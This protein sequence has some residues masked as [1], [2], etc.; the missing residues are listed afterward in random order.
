MV[1]PAW[2]AWPERDHLTGQAVAL[3]A[4]SGRWAI[5]SPRSSFAS[6]IDR[7]ERRLAGVLNRS[8]C[9]TTCNGSAAIVIA[10]QA[11]GIGPGD[12]VLVPATTWVG[13]ATAVLRVGARPIFVDAAANFPLAATASVEGPFQAILAVHLY[14]SQLE[15]AEL[16]AR[17]PGVPLIEDLSHCVTAVGSDG[18]PLG[19]CGEIA[20]VSFQATKAL[21]CGEG[22][23]AFTDSPELANRLA[24]LRADSRLR[25][26]AASGLVPLR[27]G[28]IHGANFALPEISAALLCEQIERLPGQKQRR[29]AG[30]LA[31]TGALEGSPLRAVAHEC[32][33]ASGSFYGIPLVFRRQEDSYGE[34]LPKLLAPLA[35]AV[36][37]E[38]V[39]PPLPEGPLYLPET[40]PAYQRLLG[41]TQPNAGLKR[42]QWWHEHAVVIPHELLLAPPERLVRL[43]ADLAT[44]ASRER[45]PMVSIAPV[46]PDPEVTVVVL[47]RPGSGRPL[48]RAL[49]SVAK[50]TYGGPILLLVV[51]D[52]GSV[53]PVDL[54]GLSRSGGLRVESVGFNIGGFA[55]RSTIERVSLLRVLALKLVESPRVCFLDDDN[56]WLPDHLE[57]LARLLD[58]GI[59]AAHSWRTL[60]DAHGAAWCPD[61]FPWLPAGAEERWHFECYMRLGVLDRDSSVVRDQATLQFEGKELGMVDLGEWLMS[62]ELLNLL[63]LSHHYTESERARRVGEDDKLLARIRALAIPTACSERASLVYQLGGFSNPEQ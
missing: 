53:E 45:R 29:A 28:P 6:Q 46:A 4:L 32:V 43:A 1:D 59:P 22:G 57:S 47:T 25:D 41:V 20:V 39:Y 9:V 26:V 35:A 31:F 10:L 19:G 18:S 54:N 56:Q 49:E 15:V 13:C 3:A 24:A 11:L 30:A 5:A 23:A 60:V 8:Y 58:A 34:T 14:A 61:R 12:R 7:V 52:N 48:R 63:G 44:L 16:R 33:L 36:R 42:S 62:T 21:T 40:L 50:Q 17:F 51:A 55:Q 2:P 38:R 37:F 27:A